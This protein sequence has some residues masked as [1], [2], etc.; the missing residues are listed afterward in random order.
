VGKGGGRGE[1][2]MW[3]GKKEV[4]GE[5]RGGVEGGRGNKGAWYGLGGYRGSEG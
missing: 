2:G 4:E 5:V 1:L 3:R